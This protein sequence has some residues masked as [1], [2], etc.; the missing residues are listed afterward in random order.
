MHSL[1]SP[2]PE[3]SQRSD[4]KMLIERGT[5]TVT[6]DVSISAQTQSCLP[7]ARS[8][9]LPVRR[10][11][12]YVCRCTVDYISVLSKPNKSEDRGGVPVVI[13][14]Q[15][16]S[17]GN[18]E[19]GDV[20]SRLLRS[21]VTNWYQASVSSTVREGTG[22]LVDTSDG[23]CFVVAKQAK[24]AAVTLALTTA[25]RLGDPC[26][27]VLQSTN[28]PTA[29]ILANLADITTRIKQLVKVEARVRA[30]ESSANGE[31]WQV[32]V[33]AQGVSLASVVHKSNSLELLGKMNNMVQQEAN[34]MTESTRL[35]NG[36]ADKTCIWEG[37]LRDSVDKFNNVME[38]DKWS[39]LGFRKQKC[40]QHQFLKHSVRGKDGSEYAATKLNDVFN[41]AKNFQTLAPIE[42][43]SSSIGR[44]KAGK[45]MQESD[46]D[47]G[48]RQRMENQIMVE[49]DFGKKGDAAQPPYPSGS[50][51]MSLKT[52]LTNEPRIEVIVMADFVGVVNHNG[53]TQI[54]VSPQ[55]EMG[56]IGEATVEKM[57]QRYLHCQ[58]SE[59]RVFFCQKESLARALRYGRKMLQRKRPQQSIAADVTMGYCCD[60]KE[61][62]IAYKMTA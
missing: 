11:C 39:D 7:E 57:P 48:K 36:S 17:W 28:S 41:A 62:N 46:R 52:V 37:S 53:S 44:R 1:H 5:S 26:D 25:L 59:D 49:G 61:R 15:A 42:G 21:C 54:T 38:V 35:T 19:E 13:V 56:K 18:W 22:A 51:E 32:S 60:S 4:P 6:P 58:K 12:D 24:L 20:V 55:K 43:I 31:K 47:Q 16:V 10:D 29:A 9:L 27:N 40:M 23:G 30:L 33:A 2:V 8:K 50:H 45:D 34:L 3:A 14:N